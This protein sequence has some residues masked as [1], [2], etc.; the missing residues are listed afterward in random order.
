M[1]RDRHHIARA[2]LS[3]SK[4]NVRR[5]GAKDINSLAASIAALH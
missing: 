3:Q 2:D 1:S 4:L 5:Q